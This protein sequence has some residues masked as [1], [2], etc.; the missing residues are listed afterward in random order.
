MSIIDIII[1]VLIALAIF[2]GLKDGLI[3]QVGGIAGLFVG[4]ILAGR[5]SALLS[6][7]LHQWI[8]ASENIVKIISFILIIVATCFLM[9]LLG[10]LL[11]KIIT[12]TTLGWINKLGGVLLSVFGVVLL[13]G[14]LLSLIEYI[15]TSWFHL[16]PD[17]AIRQSECVKIITSVTDVVFPY[18]KQLFSGV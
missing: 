6:Q 13:I 7:Y 18:I 4:I 8:N 3:K 10:L 2:K 15:N 16:I 9:H 1:L 5:F 14:V 12:I 17:E 11:E